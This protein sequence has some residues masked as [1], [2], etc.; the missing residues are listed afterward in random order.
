MIIATITPTTMPAI[1]P[2]LRP[3][4][5]DID[6]DEGMGVL[7][8][9]IDVVAPFDVVILVGDA[10]EIEPEAVLKKLWRCEGVASSFSTKIWALLGPP[11]TVPFL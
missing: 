3:P 2:P 6:C 1:A 4:L 11:T 10:E 8:V 5:G 7:E 9:V